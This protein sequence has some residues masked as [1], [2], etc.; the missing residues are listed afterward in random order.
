MTIASVDQPKLLSRLSEALVSLKLLSLSLSLSLFIS[1]HLLPSKQQQ[2]KPSLLL[3][4]PLLS[5]QRSQGDLNLNICE[6]HAFNTLDRFSLDVFVVNGWAGETADELEDV[7]SERLAQLPS[8]GASSP[9]RGGPN[10][11][12]AGAAADSQPGA[13]SLTPIGGGGAEGGTTPSGVSPSGGSSLADG[14]AGGNSS[15]NAVNGLVPTSAL[16]RPPPSPDD[17]ELDA[18][19]VVCHERVAAGAFGDLYRG[20]YCGTD[21]AVKILRNA[22]TDTAQFAEFLQEVHIMRK[23][24]HRNVVQFIGACTQRPNLCIV[25]EYL[26]GKI[27]RVPPPPPPLF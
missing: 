8:P 2:Q 15:A 14:G 16:P 5:S 7:L 12:A 18:A 17:F 21:V 13:G 20:T 4:S 27:E 25:F 9:P 19:E 24:R 23:V 1:F 10:A 6:A 3:S 11:N 22:A 26:P